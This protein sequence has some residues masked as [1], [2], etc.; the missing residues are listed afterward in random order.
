MFL[1][2]LH[3]AFSVFLGEQGAYT[4]AMITLLMLRTAGIVI[5]V[6]I[7]LVSVN[8]LLHRRRQRQAVHDQISEPVGAESTQPL[9]PLAQQHVISIQ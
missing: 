7:I 5:P 6:Y 2:V 9:P 1:L 3:D 4:V 8:E